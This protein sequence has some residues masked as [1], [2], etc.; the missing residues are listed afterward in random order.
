MAK[1]TVELA[2]RIVAGW[3]GSLQRAEGPAGRAGP[4]GGEHAE[5]D[6]TAE[7]IVAALG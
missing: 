2:E 3:R 6:P 7:A 1:L 4:P 5:P